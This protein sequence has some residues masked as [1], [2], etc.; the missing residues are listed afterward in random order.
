MDGQE[1]I[2]KRLDDLGVYLANGQR[3]APNI[4]PAQVF[5]GKPLIRRK[6]IEQ[7]LTEKR[8]ILQESDWLTLKEEV[9]NDENLSAK[10]KLL[11]FTS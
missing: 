2:N 1:K 9:N 7:Y 10:Q 3:I 8:E 11:I 6:S 5:N 4:Q